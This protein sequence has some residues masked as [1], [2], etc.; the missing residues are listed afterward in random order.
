MS[1]APFHD[2]SPGDTLRNGER[3]YT[4]EERIAHG[5]FGAAFACRDHWGY[6][7]VLR[8]VRPFSRAYENVRE[9]WARQAAELRRVQH[10]NLVHVDDSFEHGGR[11]HLVLERCDFRLDRYIASPAWDGSRWFRAIAR[12]VLCALAHVHAAGYT[13]RNLHPHNVFCALHLEHLHPD[14][15]FSG[16]VKLGDLEVNVLLGNVDVL[17]AKLPRWL[18]P[19]EYLNPSDLGPM[20]HR[21]DIYQ[22]GLLLLCVLQGRIMRY[23]FEEISTGLPAK[24]AENLESGFGRSVARSLQLKVADRFDSALE[25]WQSLGGSPAELPV[26]DE[27]R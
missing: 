3:T 4:V 17:N 23:S 16:A 27:R 22:A 26:L 21:V 20:D 5:K 18:V 9:T 10:P 2:Y 24:H 8:I 19:P 6:P 13:H 1:E 25:L 7:R 15:I 14:S 12:A 11:F